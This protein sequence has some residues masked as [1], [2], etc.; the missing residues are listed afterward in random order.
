MGSHH[1]KSNRTRDIFTYFL[2][3]SQKKYTLARILGT[4]P[5]PREGMCGRWVQVLPVVHS[6]AM[7]LQYQYQIECST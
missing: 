4:D 7:L 1:E 2:Q 6:V 5:P 3:Q